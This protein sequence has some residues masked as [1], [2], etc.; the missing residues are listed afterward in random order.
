MTAG[1]LLALACCAALAATLPA[2]AATTAALAPREVVDQVRLKDL[3]R[4]LGWRDNALIGYGIVTGLAGSGDSPRSNVTRQ[5][6]SN[7]LSRLGANIPGDALQSR[8]V[9]AVMVTA[10]LPPSAN[11]GDRIDVTV[12][13]IGDARSLVGGILQMTPLLG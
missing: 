13:S 5:A 7:V 2:R 10:T 9:A 8:N 12:T 11:V 6:L 3:G 4:F 1:K